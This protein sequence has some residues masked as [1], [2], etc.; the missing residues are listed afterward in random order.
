MVKI[1]TYA[2]QTENK[3]PYAKGC[4]VCIACRLYLPMK[5][6]CG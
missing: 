2:K 6:F 5:C 1:R 4:T 3:Q